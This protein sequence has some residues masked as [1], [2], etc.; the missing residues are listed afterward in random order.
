M[1]KEKK[2]KNKKVYITLV[3]LVGGAISYFNIEGIGKQEEKKLI[4]DYNYLK[5]ERVA[6]GFN[7]DLVKIGTGNVYKIEPTPRTI[8]MLNRWEEKAKLGEIAWPEI[9]EPADIQKMY[10]QYITILKDEEN[11]KDE[12]SF[13]KT[14]KYIDTGVE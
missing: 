8:D 9:T 4:E 7:A 6:N 10:E 14:L 5:L 12:P 3:I 2:L 1:K 11:K 13:R